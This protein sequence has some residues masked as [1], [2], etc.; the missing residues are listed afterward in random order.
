MVGFKPGQL[1][2]LHGLSNASYN[3]KIGRVRYPLDNGRHAVELEVGEVNSSIN[4]VIQVKPDN[5]H[6]C[7]KL[8]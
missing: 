4:R 6:A 5:V 8:V 3:G 2:Y 1:V 7:K